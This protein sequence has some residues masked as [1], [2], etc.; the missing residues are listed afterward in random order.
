M[1]KKTGK[2][3]RSS[4]LTSLRSALGSMGA[5]G[6]SEVGDS[7]VL[8]S[9]ASA[10]PCCF[11]PRDDMINAGEACCTPLPNTTRGWCQIIL[12]CNVEG[13]PTQLHGVSGR[14]IK[15]K[16]KTAHDEE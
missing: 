11:S 12:G 10:S 16:V 14:R 4:F 8:S 1:T 15:K 2:M 13:R 7:G 5:S 9:E 6:A 3:I